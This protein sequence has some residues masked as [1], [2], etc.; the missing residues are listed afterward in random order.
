MRANDSKFYLSY[1]NKLEDQYNNTYHHSINKKPINADYSGLTEIFFWLR[2]ILKL[3]SLKL[4]IESELL[5]IRIF[6]LKIKLKVGQ[7]KYLLLILFWKL[8][9][10]FIKLK[11]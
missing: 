8:V 7:V 10:G 1:L 9:L 3:L 4:M 2:P 11:I 5:S 6:L